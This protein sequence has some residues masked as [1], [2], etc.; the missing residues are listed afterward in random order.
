MN[1]LLNAVQKKT[2]KKLEAALFTVVVEKNK[3]PIRKSSS[4]RQPQIIGVSK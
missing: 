4:G 3:I 1:C 2:L